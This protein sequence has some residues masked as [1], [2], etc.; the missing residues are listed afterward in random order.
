V[1]GNGYALFSEF[2]RLGGLVQAAREHAVVS[3]ALQEPEAYLAVMRA[4]IE[5][6]KK[7]E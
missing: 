4:R 2:P 7:A 6:S 5:K 3:K 1:F